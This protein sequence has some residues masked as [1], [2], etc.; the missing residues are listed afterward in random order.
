MKNVF[1]AELCTPLVHLVD[2]SVD[3]QVSII[4]L[5]LLN[6]YRHRWKAVHNILLNVLAVIILL[7]EV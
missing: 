7:K 5:Q 4:E 3:I 1:V 2:R 6:N